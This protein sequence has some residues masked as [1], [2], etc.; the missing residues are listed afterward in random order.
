MEEPLAPTLELHHES[1][2]PATRVLVLRGELDLATVPAFE[3]GLEEALEG[4]IRQVVIDLGQVTFIDST[5]IMAL[6]SALRMLLRRQARMALAC[7]NPTVLR[8]FQVT[9]TDATF[10]I[11]P[12]RE[13]ALAHLGARPG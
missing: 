1:P 10:D 9:R 2:D 8:L 5:G 11:F 4:D 12:T 7:A 3:Q 6:L 13:Q